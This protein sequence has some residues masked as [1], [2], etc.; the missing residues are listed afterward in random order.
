MAAVPLAHPAPNTVL[1]LATNASD[2]HVGGVL[3]QLTGGRWQPL[4]F[5]S[6]KLSGAGTR[7][8]TF[9]RELLAAFSAV[10]HFR[11]LLEGRQPPADRPQAA[12]HIP[13]P[14][15]AAVVGPLA[16]PTLL[17]SRIHIRHQT[18]TR[19]GERG[20]GRLEP[21]SFYSCAAAAA[22]PTAPSRPHRRGLA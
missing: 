17:H 13:V 2:T 10:R 20:S 4:G 3:Q 8:S 7:Y 9:D 21:P 18:H 19:P 6:K 5:Y 22:E 16:A 12:R 15:H 1:S 11:F 14:H